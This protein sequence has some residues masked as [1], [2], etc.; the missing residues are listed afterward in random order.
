[1]LEFHSSIL[2]AAWGWEAILG[3]QSYWH[4]LLVT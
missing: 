3:F 1:M 2:G 4:L